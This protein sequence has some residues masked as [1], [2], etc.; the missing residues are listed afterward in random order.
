MN[1]K[2]EFS[3][4]VLAVFVVT[5][6][7]LGIL[8]GTAPATSVSSVV[9]ALPA[10]KEVPVKRVVAPKPVVGDSTCTQMTNPGGRINWQ[11]SS[12]SGPWATDG[13]VSLPSLGVTAPIVRVGVNAT[14]HMVVPGN[15]RQVAWL[16]QGP[17]PG[18]TNNIVLAG[19]IAYSH[20]AGSFGRI[21]Q[22]RRGDLV[23]VAMGGKKWTFRVVWSCLFDRNTDSAEKVMGYT[24]VPSVTLISCG[25]VWDPSAGTHAKRAAVRAELVSSA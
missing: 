24:T 4:A 18:Q 22:L 2:A 13:T 10:A 1:R 14:G 6:A 23:T 11:P 7:S 21:Q 9:V 3:A 15:A 16:D 25:G 17:M 19:H 20:V 12:D 8:V 5:F